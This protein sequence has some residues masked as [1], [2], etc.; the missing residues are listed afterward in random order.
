MINKF[1]FSLGY[2]VNYFGIG[3]SWVI[4]VKYVE[5]I[6][7]DSM[8]GVCFTC[9][10]LLGWFGSMVAGFSTDFLP[11]ADSPEQELLDN[12]TYQIILLL[13]VICAVITVIGLFTWVNHETPY[14]YISNG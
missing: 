2:L 3:C 1:L 11:P 13:P 14:Y 8:F 12:R 10:E 4:V 7:P 9:L 5:E 6:V